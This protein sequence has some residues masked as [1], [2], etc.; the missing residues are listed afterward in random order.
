MAVFCKY[1]WRHMFVLT[2]GVVKPARGRVGSVLERGSYLWSVALL[3]FCQCNTS[4]QLRSEGF[5]FHLIG[6]ELKN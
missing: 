2:D 6:E 3:Y 1:V 5:L 4:R